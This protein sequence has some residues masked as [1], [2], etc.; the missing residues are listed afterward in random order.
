MPASI[1][2]LPLPGVIGFWADDQF[3]ILE[4]R[5][6]DQRLT[7][8]GEFYRGGKQMSVPGTGNAPAFADPG[9]TALSSRQMNVTVGLWK[10]VTFG[11]NRLTF[12]RADSIH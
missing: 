7:G 11:F 3:F 8:R 10:R 1:G 4:K 2:R 9:G 5:R 6:R 12:W